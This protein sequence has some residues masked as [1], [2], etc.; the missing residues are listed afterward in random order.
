MV[1]PLRPTPW[2]TQGCAARLRWAGS[3]CG[4]PIRRPSSGRAAAEQRCLTLPAAASEAT[5]A[6]QPCRRLACEVA[7]RE[8]NARDARKQP[9]VLHAEVSHCAGEVQRCAS[10]WAESAASSGGKRTATALDCAA[11]APVLPKLGAASTTGNLG[12]SRIFPILQ[13]RQESNCA[14]RGRRRV[15]GR[16][17]AQAGPGRPQ[18]LLPQRAP[19]VVTAHLAARFQPLGDG[20]WG[21][22]RGLRGPARGL[23]GLAR[24][25]KA[26]CPSSPLWGVPRRY[27]HHQDRR[28]ALVVP[29]ACATPAPHKT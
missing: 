12:S 8:A 7:Q 20:G 19:L 25:C 13:L 16:Q 3:A 24:A 26:W 17:A 2:Q 22:G 23:M 6:R 14:G 5:R 11:A 1:A 28:P 10:G 9:P 15:R 18:L 27:T 4:W 29:H 21:S